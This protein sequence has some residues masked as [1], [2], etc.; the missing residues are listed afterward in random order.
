[1]DQNLKITPPVTC[2]QGIPCVNVNKATYA[3]RVAAHVN[4]FFPREFHGKCKQLSTAEYGQ[5]DC[6][7]EMSGATER[8]QKPHMPVLT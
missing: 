4:F 2:I 7:F 5:Y 3:A 1:M 8:P 6:F